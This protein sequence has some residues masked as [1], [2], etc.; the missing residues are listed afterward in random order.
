MSL[1]ELAERLELSKTGARTHALR[2]EGAG[3]VQRVHPPVTRPGRPPVHFELTEAGADTFPQHEPELL[4]RLLEFL[5]GRGERDTVQAFFAEV[6]QQRRA[7]F[8]RAL[9]EMPDHA[10]SDRLQALEQVLA[11]DGFMPQL[12][13]EG[14]SAGRTLVVVREC[15]CP[16]PTALRATRIPCE[17]ETRFVAD[18]VG[19]QP[20]SVSLASRRSD[21]CEFRIQ[22]EDR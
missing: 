11:A 8:E 1:D 18:A 17:L 9:D 21:T 13:T 19:A 2:L 5:L 3:L 6:W 14:R 22:V 20:E 15:N 4:R 7:R 16:L 12:H 10:L